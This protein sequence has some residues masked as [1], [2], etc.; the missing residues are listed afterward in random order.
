MGAFD[1]NDDFDDEEDKNDVDTGKGD[2]ADDLSGLASLL[3]GSNLPPTMLNLM[4]QLLQSIE[5]KQ[6][7]LEAKVQQSQA[8]GGHSGHDF[9]SPEVLKDSKVK[10]P[11]ESKSSKKKDQ[12]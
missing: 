4:I 2:V 6:N 10:K 12:R 11:K 3:R 7:K 1:D 8:F 9:A 5:D